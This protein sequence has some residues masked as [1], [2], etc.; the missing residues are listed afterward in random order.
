MAQNAKDYQSR[1]LRFDP[2]LWYELCVRYSKV[3][4]NTKKKAIEKRK[5]I[6]KITL[7]S[8]SLSLSLPSPSI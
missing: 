6:T 1:D 7:A 8:L 4:Y 3:N 5:K 2:T